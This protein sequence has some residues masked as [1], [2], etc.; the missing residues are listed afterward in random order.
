MLLLRFE[1]VE[2]KKLTKVASEKVKEMLGRSSYRRIKI[3]VSEDTDFVK[4]FLAPL[5]EEFTI[6]VPGRYPD[7]NKVYQGLEDA[8][9]RQQQHIAGN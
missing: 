9:T 8:Y 2:V 6:E 5:K 1:P 7:V 3:R 4:L